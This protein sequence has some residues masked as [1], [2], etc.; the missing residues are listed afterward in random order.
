MKLATYDFGGGN[1]NQFA[2]AADL[3]YDA[4]TSAGAFLL[5]SRS[6]WG[7]ELKRRPQ[8]SSALAMRLTMTLARPDT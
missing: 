8:G 3:D 5:S 4:E 7:L 6:V 2:K 1:S